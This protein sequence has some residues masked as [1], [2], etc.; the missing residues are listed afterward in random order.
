[1][2]HSVCQ[3]TFIHDGHNWSTPQCVC[4]IWVFSR[5]T[6]SIMVMAGISVI[7]PLEFWCVE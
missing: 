5:S 7:S 4:G 1:L 2:Q 3:N 6:C